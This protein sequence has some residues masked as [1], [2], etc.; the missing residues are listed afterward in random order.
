M[1]VAFS[2]LKLGCEP[3]RLEP[4]QT[5]RLPLKTLLAV[6]ALFGATV[7]S[8]SPVSAH[9]SLLVP[10]ARYDGSVAMQSK[11]CPCGVG[12]SNRLC[13]IPT[14]RSDDFRSPRVTTLEAG[15]T[16]MLR[17]DE[18]IGHAGRY[19]IAF[20]PDGADLADFNANIITDFVDPMG[21]VG[22]AGGSIWEVEVTVPDTPCANCTLQLIQVM[23]GNMVDPVPDPA[24]RSSYYQCADIV[25]VAA[26]ADMGSPTP[27]AGTDM[28]TDPGP[29]PGPGPMPDTGTPTPNP[30]PVTPRPDTGQ[31]AMDG[32]LANINATGS[33]AV[34]PADRPTPLLLLFGALFLRRRR[35]S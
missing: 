4:S 19:R 32:G 23:D 27:D 12:E 3:A 31:S 11:A 10:A 24:G 2:G 16:I 22:N 6:G 26:G 17:W 7:V 13:D 5:M 35:R 30:G 9:I 14:D 15:S 28:G 18:Y 33:C 25:I 21:N 34:T 20:D 8:A 1:V 29:G